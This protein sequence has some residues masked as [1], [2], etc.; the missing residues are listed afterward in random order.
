MPYSFRMST[1]GRKEQSGASHDKIYITLEFLVTI[2]LKGPGKL[3]Y[4]K[5]YGYSTI[6]MAK[7][8]KSCAVAECHVRDEGI[9]V[10]YG[11]LSNRE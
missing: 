10:T 7:H 8:G 2:S 3:T 5:S 9:Y 11:S 4:L 6:F 1:V